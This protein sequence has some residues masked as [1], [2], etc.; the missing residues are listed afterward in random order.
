M[1]LLQLVVTEH[2]NQ[3]RHPI[4]ARMYARMS[5]KAEGK[6]QAEH[7]EE[8]LRGLAGRVI[9]VGAGNGLNFA[10]Y[11]AAVEEVVAVEP[12]EH[13]REL[14]R[15]AA[16]EVSARVNVV[17]G[18]ADQLPGNEGSFDA[19]VA[20]LVLCTVPDQEAA[21]GELFRVIRAGGELRFYEHVV[22]NSRGLAR[23]QRI[24]DATLWPRL[25]G[26]CHL[27]RDTGAA[28][29]RAGFIIESSR[30]FP[31]TPMPF[32]PKIPHILGVARRP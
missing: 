2:Q 29:E 7:R 1:L 27:S 14:A 31:F 6:G 19:G 4:F 32:P 21:L 8:F 12:E 5:G 28:I 22:A 24:A 23:F 10:H 3:V 16:T 9:E 20:P 17:D 15:Q 26:G 18:L 11:P 25:G 30:R 13:L